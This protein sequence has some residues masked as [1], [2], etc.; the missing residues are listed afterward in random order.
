MKF[1]IIYGDYNEF[2]RV[3]CD[4]KF[5]RVICDYKFKDFLESGL[6]H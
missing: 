6:T 5:S 1:T 4:Y 2:N 3:I